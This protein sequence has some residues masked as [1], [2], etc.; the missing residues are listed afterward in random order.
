MLTARK[1]QKSFS[2]IMYFSSLE[3]TFTSQLTLVEYHFIEEIFAS[4]N[5][6]AGNFPWASLKDIFFIC[7]GK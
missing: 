5:W 2:V 1:V 4:S 6:P 7:N 3:N